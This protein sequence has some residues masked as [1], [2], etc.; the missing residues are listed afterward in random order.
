MSQ[1]RWTDDQLQAMRQV[2]D[3]LADAVV[4]R[5]YE[6]DSVS[7]VNRLLANLSRPDRPL[8]PAIQALVDQYMAETAVLPSW[9][10]PAL[11]EACEGFF[12]SHG[13][14]SSTILCCASLPECY[15]DAMDAPVLAS[16]T[17]LLQ[18]VERRIFETAYMVVTVMQ[19]GGMRDG[20]LGLRCA[21]RVR[22]M[23]AAVRHLLRADYA[24]AQAATA[25]GTPRR[26][27]WDM[28]H[29]EPINQEA[30][31]FVILTFS[32]VGLRSLERLGY[33]P[34][35]ELRR[36]YMHTWSVIG[37]VMGVREDL[38]AHTYEEGQDLFERIKRRRRGAS[39]EGQALTAAM[40]DWMV[41]T[42]PGPLDPLPKMLL[43][44]LMG[45]E[46]AALL[47]IVQ[48]AHENEE[49]KVFAKIANAVIDVVEALK[50]LPVVR[51]FSEL[52]FRYFTRAIWR[53]HPEWG[54]EAF[55]L[56]P[57]LQEAW[58]VNEG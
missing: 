43:C 35:P 12:S 14:L 58:R 16:T 27:R 32:Y 57:A 54:Q 9:A 36:A 15:L 40:L 37:H 56:P 4:A 17:Q 2:A 3:P 6:T 34:A 49:E 50:E 19:P 42:L 45:D 13:T 8:A 25:A 29:G 5:I 46:D 53:E 39:P 7:G 31:A 33:H 24:A 55:G 51:R 22:L 23:H 21:Q 52:L 26:P 20:G 11:I 18:H 1:E 41:K 28:A 30:M 48:T 47:G 10:D 44:Q 38:L